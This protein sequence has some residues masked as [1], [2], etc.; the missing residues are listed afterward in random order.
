M[1]YQQEEDDRGDWYSN[2]VDQD[3]TFAA[4][5]QRQF[6]DEDILVSQL[7][8]TF[9]FGQ[10]PGLTHSIAPESSSNLKNDEEFARRLQ[11]KFFLDLKKQGFS[12]IEIA[13]MLDNLALE[14][15]QHTDT[16][17]EQA[18][19]ASLGDDM[20]SDQ[21]PAQTT[22]SFLE[23][24]LF[25]LYSNCCYEIDA[26][27]QPPPVDDF[28]VFREQASKSI[29]TMTD[30]M[31]L[32]VDKIMENM[33]DKVLSESQKWNE[34]EA[35]L[36]IIDS[37][38]SQLN[39]TTSNLDNPKTRLLRHITSLAPNSNPL[40]LNTSINLIG[41]LS[42]WLYLNKDVAAA[43]INWIVALPPYETLLL[44]I[45]QVL[46]KMSALMHTEMADSFKS[47]FDFLPYIELTSDHGP[48]METAALHLIKACT[49]LLND[50]NTDKLVDGLKILTERPIYALN[51]LAN[52]N[53]HLDD[54]A[55][56]NSWHKLAM[57]PNVWIERIY[58]TFKTLHP[59]DSQ[60][61]FLSLKFGENPISPWATLAHD[62]CH[63]ICKTISS[64]SNNQ[65]IVN[66]CCLCFM[67]IINCDLSNH[68][69]PLIGC[70]LGELLALYGKQ[71][72]N[73]L[74]LAGRIVD[75]YTVGLGAEDT[76]ANFLNELCIQID[77]GNDQLQDNLEIT[78]SLFSMVNSFT[79]LRLTTFI[80]KPAC[81]L[82]FE[83]S[84]KGLAIE[85]NE[86][87]RYARTFIFMFLQFP[88]NQTSPQLANALQNIEMIVSSCFEKLIDNCLR[89]AMFQ[90]SI[91]LVH[92]ASEVLSEILLFESQRMDGYLSQTIQ[93]LLAHQSVPAEEIQNFE[94]QLRRCLSAEDVLNCV[95][96][97]SRKN[98]N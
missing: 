74:N 50:T 80:E 40:L 46:E 82:M 65:L 77:A 97:F 63:I 11:R 8:S 70:L 96:Y 10:R 43:C 29:K 15:Q 62:I 72:E 4:Q 26:N 94:T 90:S 1:D 17:F 20:Q 73:V 87:H 28:S 6:D 60:F 16:E 22:Q 42:H 9:N 45:S 67:Q 86:I 21:Q 14:N 13:S 23:K 83:M 2:S 5:L 58:Q 47:I 44:S 52:G 33:L 34:I 91:E 68:A 3:A 19:R 88:R 49:H 18:I 64:Y 98:H 36:F 41:N 55:N 38:S 7:G 71:P 57:D 85:E 78:K 35:A 24:F 84:I 30:E 95:V 75:E 61:E 56:N 92:T 76:I 93:R 48:E 25:T 89:V 66:N 31:L 69:T 53:Q 39:T 59:W 12:E 37:I 51:E 54:M 81:Q 32:S 79:R 27:V